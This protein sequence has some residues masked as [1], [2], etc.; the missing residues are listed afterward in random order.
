MVS[1]QSDSAKQDLKEMKAM[2]LTD[3]HARSRLILV[4]RATNLTY[5]SNSRNIPYVEM[6]RERTAVIETPAE[7]L[8]KAA[9]DD[10]KRP[11][12]R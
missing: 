6:Y 4:S 9:D 7:N 2:T 1:L 12:V 11:L 3:A 5:S 10:A 8:Q